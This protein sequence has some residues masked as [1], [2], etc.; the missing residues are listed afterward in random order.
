[1]AALLLEEAVLRGNVVL[2]KAINFRL[3]DE[4][5]ENRNWGKPITDIFSDFPC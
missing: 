4:L 3:I 5:L 1:V 2:V